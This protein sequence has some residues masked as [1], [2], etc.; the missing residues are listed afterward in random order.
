MKGRGD[1][2]QI[3]FSFLPPQVIPQGDGSVIL[4]P[5]KPTSEV[6]PKVAAQMLGVSKSSVYELIQEGKL[7]YRRPLKKKILITTASIDAYR[8]ETG[9]P[10]YWEQPPA[11][12]MRKTA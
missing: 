4:K 11:A 1:C 2:N 7:V 3:L 6:S 12:I 9:D 10:E 5:G 8:T